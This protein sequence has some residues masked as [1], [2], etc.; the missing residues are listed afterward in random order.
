M[1]ASHRLPGHG[2]RDRRLRDDLRRPAFPRDR[3]RVPGTA[4]QHRRGVGYFTATLSGAVVLGVL[5]YI[6]AMACP[7]ELGVLDARSFRLHLLAERVSQVWLASAAAMV[8]VQAADDSGL[9]V[10]RLV[11]SGA[12]GDAIGASEMSRGWIATTI[13]SAVVAV[14]LRLTVR[15]IWH[16]VLLIPSLI[17]VVAVPVT[18]NAGQGP[19]HDF[20][21]S[22]M[23]VFMLALTVLTGAKVCAVLAPPNAQL[24]RRIVVI[25]VTSGSV[26]LLYGALLLWLMLSPT[27]L[28]ASDYGRLGIVASA[29]LISVWLVD[30]TT[31]LRSRNRAIQ[32][33]K[34]SRWQARWR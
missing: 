5:V 10:A 27:A 1:G 4:D 24:L 22:S 7:D 32:R 31:L 2:G 28:T 13:F 33:G 18:G 19:H 20:A 3:R 29:A 17:A 16:V 26:S 15:W 6:V 23:I 25:E 8:L 12:I 9:A 34:E 30:L 11:A 21:T 14:A